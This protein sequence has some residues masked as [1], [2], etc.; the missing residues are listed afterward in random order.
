MLANDDY[1]AI[2]KRVFFDA[3]TIDIGAIGAAEIFEKGVFKNC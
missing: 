1:V 2:A 3:L